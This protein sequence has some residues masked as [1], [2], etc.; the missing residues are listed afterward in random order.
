MFIVKA[1]ETFAIRLGN[2][3][4]EPWTYRCVYNRR[5]QGAT[6]QVVLEGT[7]VDDAW[8]T[9][10]EGLDGLNFRAAEIVSL[11]LRGVAPAEE[12][13]VFLSK[14]LPNGSRVLVIQRPDVLEMLYTP[15][16]GFPRMGATEDRPTLVPTGFKYLD[17]TLGKHVWYN[18]GEG[19]VDAEGEEADEGSGPLGFEEFNFDDPW[20]PQESLPE[21]G[22]FQSVSLDDN[23]TYEL[24]PLAGSN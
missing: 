16:D 7:L 9:L 11:E 1:G 23:D 3:P 13:S 24:L 5:G 17:V 12:R 10:I 21:A 2:A 8:V 14:L 19:W 4:S 22:A 18:G 20:S 6:S 15:E